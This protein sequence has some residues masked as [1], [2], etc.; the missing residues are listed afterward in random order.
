VQAGLGVLGAGLE[1]LSMVIDPLGTL[2]SYGVSWLIE[3]GSGGD[4]RL[5]LDPAG[6]VVSVMG[7]QWTERYAYDPAGAVVTAGHVH[8]QRDAQGRMVLRQRRTLSGRTMIWRYTWD[9]ED[10]LT[11]V[12]T[13]DGARWRYR[14]DALGRRVAKQQLGADGAEV[15]AQV[16]FTWEGT[17]LA[18]QV[19]SSGAAMS[20][21]YEPRGH[22][23]AT[24]VQRVLGGSQ[25]WVDQEFYSIVTDLVG[26]PAELVDPA[27]NTVWRS[28]RSLWGDTVGPLG[29]TPL[30]FPGHT[31]TRKPGCTTTSCATT[32]RWPAG[33]RA[34][35]RSACPAVPF[36]TATST[37]RCTGST[38]SA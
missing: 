37:T 21:D 3:H 30:R 20:W 31:S 12:T 10:R 13:P 8:Q 19:D 23:P 36:R 2:A 4:R 17:T 26:A 22:R 6:R 38:R 18:E 32:T 27:G 35:T 28:L 11:G 33:T 7:P 24:Q 25:E 5:Q 1:V 29:L 34:S 9:V 14:Y 16:E 15:L